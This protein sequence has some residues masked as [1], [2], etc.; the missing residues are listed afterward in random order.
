MKPFGWFS[1]SRH[2]GALQRWREAWTAAI[3]GPAD[4]D[5]EL[6]AQLDALSIGEPDIELECEMLD[7][8]EALRTMQRAIANGGPPII[9]THHRVIGTEACHF[10]APA[11]IAT[12][13]AQA[14]GR[15]LLTRTRA[16]FV[17]AGRTA[18]T[19]W[20]QV[21]DVARL[22]RDVLLARP[23]QTP[24]AHFRFN[25]YA[26]AVVCAFLASHLKPVKRPRL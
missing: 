13:Q 9:E 3:D 20:H 19:P 22:Q 23:D 5:A 10:T 11:S 18:A 6:R 17:G 12:D 16:V 15:V 25:T 8:L 4:S 7:A 24:V 1:K 2:D 14:A 26:D 21:H